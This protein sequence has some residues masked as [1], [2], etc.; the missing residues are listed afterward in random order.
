MK[1]SRRPLPK[2]AVPA[3]ERALVAAIDDYRA[4]RLERA[5]TACRTLLRHD[6]GNAAAHQLLAVV[7]LQQGEPAAGRVHIERSLVLRPD[8]L[9]SLLIAGRAARAADDRAAALA[10]VERAV[11]LAPDAEE[12]A[13]LRGSLLRE[14]GDPRA[15]AVLRALVARHQRH[16]QGW[17]A[18]GEAL[19]D[20]GDLPAALAA[21]EQ[22]AAID[23]RLAKAHFHRAV[24][25]HA[26]ERFAEAADSFRIAQ[27]L[28]PDAAEI[29][30]NLALTLLRLGTKDAAAQAFERTVALQPSHVEAWF[31]LG[32]VRQDLNDLAGAVQALNAVLAARPE[33]AEAAV[34]LGIVLQAQ[35]TMEAAM[36]AYAEAVRRRPETFGPVVQA[37]CGASTGRLWL[38]PAALRRS[39]AR[40]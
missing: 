26:A 8:H 6:D 29:A 12:P 7:L 25:L 34:N 17:C 15:T 32:L 40:R 38:D 16:A 18:L 14:L 5:A 11:A 4:G 20:A 35:G 3:S 19:K 24:T 9:A 33:H 10:H 39:L 31:S 36:T 2:A 30:F 27:S 13:Y 23:P 21:F 28:A 22:A 37:L 1:A